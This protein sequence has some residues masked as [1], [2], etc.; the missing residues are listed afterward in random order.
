MYMTFDIASPIVC[1]WVSN[2][3]FKNTFMRYFPTKFIGGVEVFSEISLHHTSID[4]ATTDVQPTNIKAIYKMLGLSNDTLLEYGQ[5]EIDEAD[6]YLKPYNIAAP[7][8]TTQDVVSYINNNSVKREYTV[9]NEG[10]PTERL[11]HT[12]KELSDVSVDVVF[13]TRLYKNAYKVVRTTGVHSMTSSA[14]AEVVLGG[15]TAVSNT[16]LQYLG[17]GVR[18]ERIPPHMP[19]L[20][21]NGQIEYD[22]NSSKVVFAALHD[23]KNTLF[24]RSADVI[25]QEVISTHSGRRPAYDVLAT[26]RFTF[27]R[28]V[29]AGDPAG[30]AV[31]QEILD[32]LNLVPK[33]VV[34]T[35]PSDGTTLTMAYYLGTTVKSSMVNQIDDCRRTIQPVIDSDLVLVPNDGSDRGY[36]KKDVAALL[37]GEQFVG[38]VQESLD[39]DVSY[40]REGGGFFIFLLAVA[41]I[42]VAIALAVPSGGTTL[43]GIPAVTAGLGVAGAELAFLTGIALVLT[44]ETLVLSAIA[45]AY[46]RAGGTYQAMMIGSV[47]TIIG[48]AQQTFGILLMAMGVAQVLTKLGELAT[49]EATATLVSELGASGTEYVGTITG[50][51]LVN[52]VVQPIAPT[53]SNYVTATIELMLPNFGGF[54]NMSTQDLLMASIKNVTTVGNLYLAYVAPHTDPGTM[55]DPVEPVSTEAVLLT[56]VYLDDNYCY[57]LNT[58]MELAPYNMTEGLIVNSFNKYYKNG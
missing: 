7:T 42:A 45:V 21:L 6:L 15:V 43:N 25:S 40:H 37:T 57:E 9:V 16:F 44:L 30:S 35:N 3:R 54:T 47:L 46:Q 14:I 26:V 28:E 32:N 5:S 38:M 52:G 12:N 10:L 29:D 4:Q 11:V 55:P 19:F 31:I 24:T 58:V 53:L 1:D 8:L 36:I 49:A 2:L 34:I 56:Q 39:V 33:E 23:T 50:D 22:T 13:T 27:A 48:M 41:L 20:F 51:I 17:R 18:G